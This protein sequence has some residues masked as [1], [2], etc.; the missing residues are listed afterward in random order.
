MNSILFIDIQFMETAAGDMMRWRLK[1]AGR[2]STQTAKKRMVK[3][4]G[5]M[6]ILVSLDPG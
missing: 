2:Q 6:G 1:H 3:W 4:N 5:K